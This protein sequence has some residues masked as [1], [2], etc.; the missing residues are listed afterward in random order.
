MSLFGKKKDAIGLPHPFDA[1]E[2]GLAS[3]V[4]KREEVCAVSV[5]DDNEAKR[6]VLTI[7]FKNGGS[8]SRKLDVEYPCKLSTS[9]LALLFGCAVFGFVSGYGIAEV[10]RRI[11]EEKAK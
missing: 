9:S 7:A 3:M 2:I 11:A 1:A 8:V 5:D 10:A 4:V 6:H